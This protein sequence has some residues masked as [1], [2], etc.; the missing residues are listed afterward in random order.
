MGETS[1][2]TF[3]LVSG[4]PRHSLER[5]WS[6]TVT[7]NQAEIAKRQEHREHVNVAF[8]SLSPGLGDQLW[9]I[10]DLL[11][12]TDPETKEHAKQLLGL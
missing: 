1:Q 3:L 12:D 10:G 2:L 7:E 11:D 9:D 8:A 4:D 6:T 5:F